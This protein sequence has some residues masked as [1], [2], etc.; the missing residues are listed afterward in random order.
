MIVI[1]LIFLLEPR[2]G[3]DY[4]QFNNLKVNFFL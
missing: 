4:L 2:I 3:Q 1:P